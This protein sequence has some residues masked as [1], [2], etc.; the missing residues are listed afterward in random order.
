[1]LEPAR[2]STT[3]P[4]SRCPSTTTPTTAPSSTAERVARAPVRISTPASTSAVQQATDQGPAPHVARAG[5][6]RRW[7]ARSRRS[8]SSGRS[9]RRRRLVEGGLD[10][11]LDVG[12]QTQRPRPQRPSPG[13]GPGE[14]APVV[15]PVLEDLPLDGR[16]LSRSRR[17]RGAVSD[18]EGPHQLDV[19]VAAAGGAPDRRS[20]VV[21]AVVERMVVRHPRPWAGIHTTPPGH[22]RGAPDASARSTTST[23]AP[24][25]DAA[26]AA[27]NPAAPDPTTT[28]DR[29]PDTGPGYVP[30]PV[31]LGTTGGI[32]GS[33]RPPTIGPWHSL[34]R[35]LRPPLSSPAHHRASAP[36]WPASSPSGGTASRLL[37]RREARLTELAAELQKAHGV[38][39]EVVALDLTDPAARGGL[40]ATL[41][42]AG[43]DR[44]R[45]RQ[46]RRLQ[47]HRPRVPQ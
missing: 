36:I 1:M 45:A 24:A 23:S 4:R 19:D 33:S 12:C 26:R 8:R 35:H 38:R 7:R 29:V 21:G 47:H 34:P 46:Q 22:G 17:P 18:D 13:L 6:R 41:G 31:L 28:T 27:A 39:C 16:A 44:R 20:G 3:R 42:R 9:R 11:R 32:A 10:A 43:T 25:P 30:S 40:P 15:G 37:A 5:P 14:L 2:A